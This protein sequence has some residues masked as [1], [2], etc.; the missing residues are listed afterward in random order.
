MQMMFNNSTVKMFINVLSTANKEAI[1]TTQWKENSMQVY[2]LGTCGIGIEVLAFQLKV[3]S[4]PVHGG[5]LRWWR[6][7]WNPFHWCS[8]A[9]GPS[10]EIHF[11]KVAMS[12]S[13]HG[14]GDIRLLNLFFAHLVANFWAE[15]GERL[16]WHWATW[17]DGQMLPMAHLDSYTIFMKH[18]GH[19]KKW[20]WLII[21]T[22]LNKRR[23]QRKHTRPVLLPTAFAD[24]L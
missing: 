21:S 5:S 16:R 8:S 3:C 24:S 9:T 23:Q 14:E 22:F 10:A 2:Q 20:S 4:K 17:V 6:V 11:P 1:K 19:K 13:C 12:I 18:V 7:H 15:Y